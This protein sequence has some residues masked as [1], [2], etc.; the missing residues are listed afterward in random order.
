MLTTKKRGRCALAI[1]AAACLLL[2]GCGPPG[3]RAL[4]KGDRLVQSGKYDEAIEALTQA[5]NLLANASLPVRAK[6]H[7]LLGLAFH[8]AGKAAGARACYEAALA[9]DRNG[10]AEADYNL[11]CLEME[12]TNWLA[13]KDALTTYTSLRARDWNGFMKLGMVNYRLAMK[14]PPA[15]NAT[16]DSAR[17][18]N[19][20][21]ARKAFDTARRI[22]ATAEAW[23]N[24]AMIDLLRQPNPSHSTISNVVAEFKT[25]LVCDTN[26]APALINLA[27]VY[28]PAG[29]Y[30]YGDLPSAATAYRRYLA[31][32][33]PPP[34]AGE[35]T[36]L[37][38]NL[39]LT[40]KFAVQRPGQAPEPPEATIPIPTNKFSAIPKTN[41]PARGT[42]PL[43][44]SP[45]APATTAPPPVATL[46]AGTAAAAARPPPVAMLSGTAPAAANA[47]LVATL[48]ATKPEPPSP[49]RP[50]T[51]GA[52]SNPSVALSRSGPS[53]GS[54]STAPETESNTA[55]TNV[56]L[57]S[58]AVRQPSFFA[59]LFGAKPK[60]E[61]G[62]ADS[63][64]GASKNPARITPLPAPAPHGLLHY[65]AP[66][67]NPNPG[68]RAEAERLAREAAAAEK[69]SRGKDAMDNYEAAVK[70]DPSYYEAC[71]ALGMAAIRSGDYAIALEALHH[72]LTLNSDS[73]N[74]RYGYAWALLKKDYFQDAAN[75]LEKLLAQHPDETRAHLL[76]GNLYAQNLGQ[77][78]FARGHYKTVLEKDPRND[79]A[80]ALRAWLQNNPEP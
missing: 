65:V 69:E 6:A 40:R 3:V 44:A 79:Q 52:A 28:D 53:P 41:P 1:A 59:R 32:S 38:S 12:Q 36:L 9:L 22:K 58:T 67:V 61:E 73:A 72:A 37:V 2:T 20:S 70:A 25:A 68:N 56:P 8:R 74:A 29:P 23:N 42:T 78:D 27:V 30:K 62:G 54:V 43:P 47:P 14:T 60:P 17:Q 7:N 18:L 75:E 55:P 48:P 16:A 46:T 63:N 19:F 21:N 10:A 24:L 66:P 45:P 77:P 39:D 15:A 57:T 26:Y 4:H 35:V 80:P 51:G 34:R 11:G 33:P 71:E 31:L 5:T 64:S 50:A 13:A 76:L 49:P